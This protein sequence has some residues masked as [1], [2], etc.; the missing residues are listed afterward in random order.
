MRLMTSGG[1]EEKI[2]GREHASRYVSLCVV[3]EKAD[4]LNERGTLSRHNNEK[5]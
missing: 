5:K 2:G 4:K 3:Y 1:A